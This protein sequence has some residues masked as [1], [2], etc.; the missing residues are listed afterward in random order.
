M[1]PHN[2]VFL[3][4]VFETGSQEDLIAYRK[5]KVEVKI[6]VFLD[7][8]SGI[9]FRGG[10]ASQRGIHRVLD[11]EVGF[12]TPV[13]RTEVP[14]P[15]RVEMG[16]L[17]PREKGLIGGGA[18]E[19][20]GKTAGKAFAEREIVVLLSKTCWSASGSAT[21]SVM[22]TTGGSGASGSNLPTSNVSPPSATEDAPARIGISEEESAF[23]FFARIVGIAVEFGVFRQVSA[24]VGKEFKVIPDDGR[25]PDLGGIRHVG[26]AGGNERL[27]VVAFAQ[28]DRYHPRCHIPG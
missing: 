26:I 25:T 12:V 4:S 5:R 3:I 9:E 22:A 14:C 20:G 19:S 10:I 8:A 27:G 17:N 18:A 1:S 15:E 23:H 24:V 28:I 2:F 6:E 16:A 13:I 21:L 7:I 11:H